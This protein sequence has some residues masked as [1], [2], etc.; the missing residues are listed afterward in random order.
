M[1]FRC[2][3]L[4]LLFVFI[5]L[6]GPQPQRTTAAFDI[7]PPHPKGLPFSKVLDLAR[8]RFAVDANENDELYVKPMKG[9]VAVITGAAGGIGQGLATLIHRLGGT[10]V[11]LDRN[12]KGLEDMKLSLERAYKDNQESRI[13]TVTTHH[14]DLSSV[15]RAAEDISRRFDAIDLLIN[16]AGLT[17]PANIS[18]EMNLAKAV[19]GKDL[20]FTVNY[21]S[22]FLLTEKL[23]K[24]LINANG[25]VVHLTSTYH[26]KVDGSELVPSSGSKH[27]KAYESDPRKQG[28]RHFER[29]YGNTKLAQIYHSHWIGAKTNCSSVCACPTWAATGIGGE[30]N[31]DFLQKMAFSVSG[32]GPGLTSSINAMLRTD[33]ELG[34]ALND[35]KSFVANSRTLDY[36]K[37]KTLW[38]GLPIWR[39]KLADLIG[40]VLLLCQNM[41]HDDLI[42]Q[43]TSKESWDVTKR[44]LLYS[45]SRE[46]VQHYI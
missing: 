22:H 46:E 41:F 15:A 12:Q 24:K 35:G 6:N 8:Q 11:A 28:P 36:I 9:R 42:I 10:V 27:P 31:R 14:E 34:D 32:C 23:L 7:H 13:V 5:N 4:C 30:D 25:R 3:V 40:I 21:L 19:N 1:F 45:W 33:D 26:W 16:N 2:S 38:L 20:V 43:K 37:G 29:S 44:D 39:D 18:P 17:Y